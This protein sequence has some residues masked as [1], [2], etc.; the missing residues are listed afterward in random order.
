[1][2]KTWSNGCN[3]EEANK[4]FQA[5]LGHS[6]CIR[7]IY[8]LVRTE[9]PY[10]SCDDSG[11]R[12]ALAEMEDAF[13]KSNLAYE[14]RRDAGVDPVSDPNPPIQAS[15]VTWDRYDAAMVAACPAVG[16]F[17]LWYKE[18]N[19]PAVNPVDSWHPLQKE[20]EAAKKA[21]NEIIAKHPT[22]LL[23]Q[24]LMAKKG[25]T[26]Y[27]NDPARSRFLSSPHGRLA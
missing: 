23:Q 3:P 15:R 7:K 22:L 13:D 17:N 11:V 5:I 21:F 24:K 25:V 4:V 27:F 8:K 1:M 14:R 12:D 20:E 6:S 9:N 19:H 26:T 16:L 2:S 10:I 18:P